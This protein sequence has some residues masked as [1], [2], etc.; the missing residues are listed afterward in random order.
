MADPFAII[1]VFTIIVIAIS[2]C[3]YIYTALCLFYIA[4]RTN[5]PRAWMAWIPILNLILLADISRMYWWPVL[6]IPIIYGMDFIPGE[7]IIVSMVSLVLSIVFI[8]YMLTYWEKTFKRVGMSGWWVIALII[9]VL[10]LIAMGLAAW[11]K[12]PSNA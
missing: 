6:L 10:N 9:P 8:V 12:R 7:N 4:K 1:M 11:G 3:V 5:T 2:L